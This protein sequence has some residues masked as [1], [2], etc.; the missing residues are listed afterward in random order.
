MTDDQSES[1]ITCSKYSTLEYSM[2][3]I[4]SFEILNKQCSIFG[5]DFGSLLSCLLPEITWIWI[6]PPGY[7]FFSW[8]FSFST[9]IQL[10]LTLKLR[11]LRYNISRSRYMLQKKKN[12]K[13]VYI[14]TLLILLRTCVLLLV[15]MINQLNGKHWLVIQLVMG[16]PLLTIVCG[17]PYHL[18]FCIK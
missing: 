6:I 4:L 16:I 17:I 18:I 8:K 1:N 7:A 15:H 9:L 14:N 2:W 10:R 13:Y 3:H 11:Y 12:L 5:V